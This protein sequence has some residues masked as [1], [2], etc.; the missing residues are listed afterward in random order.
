MCW[1]TR[2]QLPGELGGAI[3]AM[4]EGDVDGPVRSEFGF[5]IVR[6][7]EILERGP[8]PLDQVRGD[9]L[10]ELR[11]REAESIFRELERKASDALFDAGDMQAISD[12]VGIE[13][14]TA[15]GFTRAGGEPIGSNQA[16]IDAVFDEQV[17]VDGQIS[18]LIELDAT[19][20][21]IFKVTAYNE[22]SR[23]PLEDVRDEVVAAIKTQEA[24]T[25]VFNRAEQLLAALDS[26]EAF[27]PAA[28]AVGAEVSAPALVSRQQEGVDAAVR[29]QVFLAAKPTADS[30]VRGMVANTGGG[31]TVFSLDAV[32]PGRP[33]SIPLADRDAGKL[34]LAQEAGISDYIAFV[35]SLYSRAEVVISEDAL[36]AQDPFQ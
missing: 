7:D 23:L 4:N 27:G 32:L 33:E 31:Y 21:A 16:A 26:G 15:S 5:H 11:D 20:S 9:L 17:L 35:E 29:S 2:T 10:T 28:E 18:E 24:E 36:A 25:L 19:R 34:Q 6:L 1:W 8:L 3:F 22:A 14:Q 30:P 12:A 13:I